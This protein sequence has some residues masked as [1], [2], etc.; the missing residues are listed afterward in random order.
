MIIVRDAKILQ[1]EKLVAT[2]GFF[3]GVHQGHRSLINEMIA[4]ARRLQ[5]PSAVITFP[6][7]PRKV[8]QADYQP[9]LLNSFEEKLSHLAETGV[10]YCIVLDF[11]ISLSELTAKTFI[12]DI[13]AKEWNVQTLFI[14]YDHRFGRD[15]LDGLQQYIQYGKMCDM[16]VIPASEFHLG[17]KTIS[18]SEVRRQLERGNVSQAAR[19]L[20]YPYQLKG[21]IVSGFKVGRKLGFPTANIQVDEQYKV[22]PSIGVYAV[23]AIL[24]D[25]RYKG[26]LYIGSRPTLNNGT[27][28]TLEVNIFDF[29]EDI[30]NCEITVIFQ[31]Y[32]RGDVRFESLEELK[33][34]LREDRGKVM[35]IMNNK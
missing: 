3:D 16:N 30:Y 20:T 25:V 31:E 28:I 32:V 8:L 17:E 6:Q 10:D 34:Q 29:E 1:H 21:H 12:Q 4:T 13:L 9:K 18:S 33:T 7:H 19:L 15:R 35:E 11:T 2:M 23:W 27:N 22:I 26:M 24:R 14:G 5:M